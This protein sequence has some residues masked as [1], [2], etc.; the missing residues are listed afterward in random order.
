[1]RTHSSV[2]RLPERPSRRPER[3]DGGSRLAVHYVLFALVFLAAVDLDQPAHAY[4]D[5]G[6]ASILLQTLLGGVA[7][8][9]VVA[10]LYWHR[11]TSVFRRGRSKA[12]AVPP[13]STE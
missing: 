3:R 1:M 12:G 5:P 8:A 4:L 10:K 13:H 7:G 6:T 11:L 2:R 9:L